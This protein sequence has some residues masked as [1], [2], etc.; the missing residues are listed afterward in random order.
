MSYPHRYCYLTKRYDR[1]DSRE[2]WADMNLDK[3]IK[4]KTNSYFSGQ[5]CAQKQNLAPNTEHI[6]RL[7]I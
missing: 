3:I 2:I 4:L 1:G 5:I 6:L 7:N